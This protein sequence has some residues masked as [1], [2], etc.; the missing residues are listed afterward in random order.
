VNEA[1]TKGWGGRTAAARS[2]KAAKPSTAQQA[3]RAADTGH[4]ALGPLIAAA[5]NA[6]VGDAAR[7]PFPTPPDGTAMARLVALFGLSAFEV[8]VLSAAAAVELV[9]GFGA[10]CAKG[11]NRAETQA[12][13]V[14]L[15]IARLPGADWSA[16]EVDGPLRRWRL[17]GLGEAP[18]FTSRPVFLRSSVLGWLMGHPAMDERLA[19]RIRPL[20]ESVAEQP[21]SRRAA[22]EQLARALQDP[23][24]PHVQLVTNS[25]EQARGLALSI[26]GTHGRRLWELPAWT[27][28]EVREDCEE[29]IRDAARDA[30]LN[31]ALILFDTTGMAVDPGQFRAAVEAAERFPDPMLIAGPDLVRSASRPVV[32]AQVDPLPHEEAVR[33]WQTALEGAGLVDGTE[34]AANPAILAAQFQLGPEAILAATESARFD[35]APEPASRRVWRAC[36]LVAR[37]RLDDLAQRI[38]PEADWDSL[39]LPPE[40][41]RAVRAIAAQVRHRARVFHDWG[42]SG[43]G[44]RTGTSA[45][46]HGPSGTGKTMAAGVLAGALDLDLYRIDLSAVVSKYIGETEKNLRQVFDAADESGA[47]LLFDEADAL[48]GKRTEVKDSHDRHAN[49][50]VSYLLQRMETYQGLAILTTNLRKNIDEAFLRRIQF[51]V[52]FP[53]PDK[54]LRERIWR[55]AFPDGMPLDRVDP[56]YLAQLAIAGGNI[57]T[58]ARNAAFLAAEDDRSV[59]MDHILEA[60]RQEYDKLGQ[61]LTAAEMRGWQI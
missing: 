23:G 16:L 57:K 39:V 13:S 58:I 25:A 47:I 53:F 56:R 37:A 38:T 19:A 40:G 61:S 3:Y 43:H 49:V 36:R 48:F 44:H 52:E 60:A 24:R 32:S 26:A 50:E 34:G 42:L 21:P 41:S 1:G 45:I 2:S 46:F 33:L 20:S 14:G 30:R 8:A 17:V 10:E 18:I 22:A 28:P 55:G 4:D 35:A 9:P 15:A 7:T 11:S 12:L 54:A 6:I 51:V 59:G 29:L 31:D 27:L 5:R